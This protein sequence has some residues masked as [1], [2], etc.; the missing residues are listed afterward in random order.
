MS[1]CL[2][3]NMGIAGLVDSLSMVLGATLCETRTGPP[4]KKEESARKD[5]WIDATLIML[6]I[7]III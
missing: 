5:G 1:R 4:Q 3:Y 2:L 6:R 7:I